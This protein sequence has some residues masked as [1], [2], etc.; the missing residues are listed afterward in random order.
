MAP[1]KIYV[2]QEL[3][4][5]ALWCSEGM[6]IMAQVGFFDLTDRVAKFWADHSG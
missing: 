3:W 4:K 5:N 6:A 1:Q 2:T